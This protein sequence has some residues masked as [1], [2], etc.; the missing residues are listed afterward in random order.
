MI[1]ERSFRLKA[2]SGQRLFEMCA[3]CGFPETLGYW[4]DAGSTTASDRIR[5]RIIRAKKIND[6]L[7]KYNLRFSD[8]GTSQYCQVSNLL[9][10]V[11]V[12]T[13]IDEVWE[14]AA[15][16][17]GRPIDPLEKNFFA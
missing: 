12:I 3:N 8:D 10:E 9:G 13:Q 16:L 4:S 14:A 5:G 11:K 2:K 15:S 17:Y 1:L 7:V 6:I